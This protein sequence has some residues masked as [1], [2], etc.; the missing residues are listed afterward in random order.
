[1]YPYVLQNIYWKQG[2]IVV[3]IIRRIFRILQSL[4]FNY[5]LSLLSTSCNLLLLY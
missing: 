2:Y 5:L 3:Y 1:M 4:Q